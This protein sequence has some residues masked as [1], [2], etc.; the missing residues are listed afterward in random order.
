MLR[1]RLPFVPTLVT[2]LAVVIMFALGVWQLQRADEKKQRLIAIDQAARSAPL[3][4]NAALALNEDARDFPVYFK[5]QADAEH[6]FLL[7]NRIQHGQVGY[8]VLLV[9][10]AESGAVLVNYGWIA[11]PAL[12]AD[13]PMV[14]IPAGEQEY[15]GML[16]IPFKNSLVNET[17]LFDQQW[18]KV[19]QQ[20][21]INLMAQHYQQKLMP[22]V[23]LL[24]EQDNIGFVRNWQAVVMPPEKHLAY[25]I[26]WFLLAF[27]AITIFIIAQRRKINR[28]VK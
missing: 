16:S 9:V 18:P 19:V 4:L 5:G 2:F 7:D 15:Q 21:D 22:F 14:A 12:R 8:E 28:E 13:L 17:A 1:S 10:D 23:I 11:A 27:A 3:S 6:Y 20:V 26:Q 24:D 25:A